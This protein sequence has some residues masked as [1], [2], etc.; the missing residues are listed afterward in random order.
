VTIRCSSRPG[1]DGSRRHN[2]AGSGTM[3]VLSSALLLLTAALAA[4]IWAMASS[5]NH[6]A[7]TAADLAALSAAGA[8]QSGELDPCRTAA[9]IAT[10]HGAELVGC[11]IDG[12]SVVVVAAVRLRLGA[13]GSPAALAGARAGPEHPPFTAWSRG[14]AR[15][16]IGAVPCC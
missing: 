10:K 13:L 12:E 3:L 14:P 11:E 5:A 4:A 15:S 1:R 8:L 2:E 7:A 16:T 6:R 9:R